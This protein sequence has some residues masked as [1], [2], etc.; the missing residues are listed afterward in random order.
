VRWCDGTNSRTLLGKRTPM[1]ALGWARGERG[2]SRSPPGNGQCVDAA[3]NR[4]KTLPDGSAKTEVDR[5]MKRLERAPDTFGRRVAWDALGD[6]LARQYAPIIV[7]GDS[8]Q[9]RL[10]SD[11]V[12]NVVLSSVKFGPDLSLLRLDP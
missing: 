12:H 5:E 9:G 1:Y 6:R 2:R 4:G 8:M 7:F 3:C 11:R 10:Y